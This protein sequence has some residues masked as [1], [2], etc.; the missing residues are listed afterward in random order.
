MGAHFH[1]LAP[2]NAGVAVSIHAPAWAHRPRTF[3]SSCNILFQIHAPRGGTDDN[4]SPVC[5]GIIVSIHAPAWARRGATRQPYNLCVSIHAPAW[6]TIDCVGCVAGRRVSIHAP[7]GEGADKERLGLKTVRFS[8]HAPTGKATVIWPKAPKYLINIFNHARGERQWASYMGF[9][10]RF[11]ST[12][13]W[14]ATK[15]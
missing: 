6:A 5:G 8:I 13:P 9:I 4:N 1:I 11:Q 2:P 12:L 14:G 10:V 15:S 7:R 3:A